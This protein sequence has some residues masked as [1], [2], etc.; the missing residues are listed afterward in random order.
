MITLSKLGRIGPVLNVGG[1][2]T[3]YELLDRPGELLKR[4]HSWVTVDVTGLVSLADW[5]STL[6]AGEQARLAA[7]TAWPIDVVD[8]EDGTFGI[9]MQRAPDAFWQ[10]VHQDK[11]PRDLSW[12]FMADAVRFAG[13]RPASPVAAVIMLYQLMTVFELFHRNGV[14]YGD[15]S[16]TN[17]LWSGGNRPV[18]FVLDCDSAA[19]EGYPRA[20]KGA[21]TTLWGC[22]WPGVVARELDEYQLA[23]AFLRLY[24]RYE[25]PLDATTRRIQLPAQPPVPRAA[26]DLLAAGLREVGIRPAASDW[27][28]VLRPMERGLKARKVT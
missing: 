10:V 25:G 24:F 11:V 23:V 3:V 22:P 13:L 12:A 19:V 18:V 5:Q 21:R 28:T 17:V 14:S 4:Y 2:G 9:V 8:C 6:A 15:M 20:L 26:A 16:S 7:T 27:L 1:Q